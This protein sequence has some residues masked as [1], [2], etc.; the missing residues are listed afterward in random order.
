ME[1]VESEDGAVS[2]DVDL[3]EL[4]NVEFILSGEELAEVEFVELEVL[5]SVES[6]V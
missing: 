3:V 2:G 1:L 5:P 4:A 6:S